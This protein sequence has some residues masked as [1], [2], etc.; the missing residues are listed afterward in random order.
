MSMVRPAVYDN[1]IVRMPAQGDLIANN[2][3]IITL[4]DAGVALALAAKYLVTGILR[5]TGPAGAYADVFPSAAD[6]VAALLNNT[7]VG[8]GSYTPVGIPPGTAFRFKYI[9]TV[10]FANTPT[11]GTGGTIGNNTVVNASSVKDY[12]VTITNGTPGSVVQGNT[13]NASAVVTGM[14][15]GQLQYITQGMLVSGT[16]IQ[17]GSTVLSVQPGV[18]VTLSLTASATGSGVALTFGPTY[19]IDGIGQGLL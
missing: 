15:A 14:N 10:A 9:N 7:Y 1:G 16:G 18:G 5:R 19:R 6:L 12:L 4:A 11:I 17:A 3:A 2:E 13:T 8:G